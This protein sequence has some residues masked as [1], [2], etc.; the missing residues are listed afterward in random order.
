MVLQVFQWVRVL[1]QGTVLWK[2]ESTEGFSNCSLKA[3]QREKVLG[4]FSGFYTFLLVELQ[5]QQVLEVAAP[6]RIQQNTQDF[7]VSLVV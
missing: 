5:I 1:Q 4:Q 7:M 6:S 3:L 2:P